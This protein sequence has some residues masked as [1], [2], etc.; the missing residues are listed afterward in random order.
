MEFA[1]FFKEL[2]TLV[3]LPVTIM[4]G[5]VI[6]YW[7][8]VILGVLGMDAIDFDLGVD[9]DLDLDLDPGLDA[10]HVGAFGESLT[11]LHLGEVPAMIVGSILVFFM[12]ILTVLSNHYLNTGDSLLLGLVFALPNVII[13]VVV[14]KGFLWP[15]LN[16]F[17]NDQTM[18]ETRENMIGVTGVVM[19]SEVTEK[20]GQI[21][22]Q[23]DGPPIVINVRT[24][25][26]EK[27]AK[28]DNAKIVAFNSAND[29]FT[30]RLSKW[31]SE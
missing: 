1:E 11:F 13:S 27:L 21:E 3:N 15:F 17:K 12:W 29:T 26:G 30:V 19:T 16:V 14:T 10:E 8:M 4:M 20:F 2:V 31:G 22:I 28:G 6:L 23:I 18:T 24:D 5:L 7:L 25:N 9:A